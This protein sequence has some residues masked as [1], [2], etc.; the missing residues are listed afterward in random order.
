MQF[1]SSQQMKSE[2]SKSHANA[3]ALKMTIL[4]TIMFYI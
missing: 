1:T 3:I 2:Q 4:Y